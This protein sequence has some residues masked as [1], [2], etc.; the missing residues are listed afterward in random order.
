MAS[1]TEKDA[2]SGVER[3]VSGVAR[4]KSGEGGARDESVVRGGKQMV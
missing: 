3:G 2:R 4:R 1:P